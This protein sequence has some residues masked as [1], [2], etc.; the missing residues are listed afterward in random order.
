MNVNSVRRLLAAVALLAAIAQP[1]SGQAFDLL[2]RGGQV[3]DGTG[4]PAFRADVGVLD[5]V[6]VQVG[7]LADADADR[8]VDAAG[9]YV[10]PGFIDMHSHAD[11]ALYSG[12]VDTRRAPNA[13]TVGNL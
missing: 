9:Q 13:D 1:A 2:I 11:R 8:V 10:T 7:D 12:D 6:I 5:G 4:N 3:L